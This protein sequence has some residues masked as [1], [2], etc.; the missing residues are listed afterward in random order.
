MPVETEKEVAAYLQATNKRLYDRLFL[1]R[2][3]AG[4]ITAISGT[5]PQYLVRID[6]TGDA[7]HACYEP[8]YM[9]QVGDQVDLMW[10]DADTGYVLTP[11][12]ATAM[13]A[14]WMQIAKIAT[15]STTPG[16][17]AFNGVPQS[18]QHLKVV[19]DCQTTNASTADLL[20]RYNADSSASY[21]GQYSWM[22]AAW[23]GTFNNGSAS[24]QAV[25]GGVS[26]NASLSNGISE[27]TIFD[28]AQAE[29]RIGCT[30]LSHRFGSTSLQT[31]EVGGFTYAPSTLKTITIVQ[32]FPSA[33]TFTA[34]D[35]FW[36]YGI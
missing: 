7:W 36:L 23:N 31:T 12:S 11:R 4:T 17:I 22:E 14:S 2:V 6:A 35:N 5:R 27:I 19:A 1:N 18:F 34:N 24:L 26:T 28:Y 13:T 15:G 20:L 9:P 16:S 10:R 25:V 32:L 30:F 3:V 21:W 33:G 29:H 8:G